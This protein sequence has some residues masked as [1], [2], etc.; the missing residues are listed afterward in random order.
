L[1]PDVIG[2]WLSDRRGDPHTRRGTRQFD[3]GRHVEV[4]KARDINVDAN[5]KGR[6]GRIPHHDRQTATTT[7]THPHTLAGLA[8]S[9]YQEVSNEHEVCS[10]Q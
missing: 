8:A 7:R 10:L 2:L 3:A 5:K 6:T 4:V 9:K 1:S